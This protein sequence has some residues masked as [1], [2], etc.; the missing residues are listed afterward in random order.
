MTS[1]QKEWRESN[2]DE[3]SIV[4]KCSVE[5]FEFRC[6]FRMD[7]MKTLGGASGTNE[8]DFDEDDGV[9]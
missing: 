5:E 4:A 1:V 8:L 3:L 2:P 7:E 6:E 9:V